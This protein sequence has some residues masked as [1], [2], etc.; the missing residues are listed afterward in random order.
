MVSITVGNN[1][2]FTGLWSIEI[3]VP[4]IKNLLIFIF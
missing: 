1:Q 4:S 2:M 3:T